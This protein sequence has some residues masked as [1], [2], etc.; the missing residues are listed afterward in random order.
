MLC[1][2][3]DIAFALWVVLW[4][5]REYW[6]TTR[7]WKP[8]TTAS[9]STKQWIL[10]KSLRQ[11]V[12]SPSTSERATKAARESQWQDPT[13]SPSWSLESTTT[14]LSYTRLIPQA[15][16]SSGRPEQLA[17]VARQPWHSSRSRSIRTW[18]W[19]RQRPSYCR[20]S[21]MSW[22]RRSLKIMLK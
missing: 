17:V 20:P 3:T 5:M 9:I 13:E 11:S 12:T 10:N 22:R 21:R 2:S 18:H 8:R 4:V 15:H 14:V 1:R 7:E 6:W 16:T 19:R